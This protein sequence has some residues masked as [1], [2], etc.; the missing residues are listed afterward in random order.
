VRL[1]LKAKLIPRM[2]RK[3]FV[4]ELDGH[5]ISA[6]VSELTL[7][8]RDRDL[9]RARITIEPDEVDVD[10]EAI[11]VLTAHIETQAAE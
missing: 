7:D 3:H 9:T 10:A 1:S 11:A 5:D 6:G 2:G 8:L 4:I